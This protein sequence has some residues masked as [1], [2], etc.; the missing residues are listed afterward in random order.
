LKK[1]FDKH[2]FEQEKYTKHPFIQ[3]IKCFSRKSIKPCRKHWRK[4]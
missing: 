3:V 4:H 1:V 2:A